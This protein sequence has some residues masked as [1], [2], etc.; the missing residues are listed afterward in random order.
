MGTISSSNRPA[1]WAASARRKL[2]V[3]YLSISSRVTLK[4]RLTFS[5]VQPMGCMQSTDSCDLEVT[6]SSKGFS[7]ASPPM[8]MDSAPT[9][10]PISM[11]P[12]LMAWA[13][14]ATALRPDE[15]KR[16]RL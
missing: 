9:A 11:E 2:S 12:L 16:F 14:S 10:R 7:R 13:M 5:L 3:A 4:S 8:D 1:F 15:Q 6:A